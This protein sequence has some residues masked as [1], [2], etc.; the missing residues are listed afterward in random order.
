[1]AY[2]AP[3]IGYP[4]GSDTVIPLFELSGELMVAYGR[5]IKDFSVNKYSRVTSVKSTVGTYLQFNPLD[6][7]RMT[8]LPASPHWAPGT[9]RPT[10]GYETLG[11]SAQPFRTSREAWAVTLDKRSV[12]V[13]NF[14]VMKSHTAALGQR[15]MTFRAYQTCAA[16]TNTNNF[17][18]THVSTATLLN[19]AGF[20]Q[21]GT[22]SDPRWM[23]TLNAAAR[24]IQQD[25]FSAVRYGHL[26]VLMNHN[27]ALRLAATRELREYLMQQS[28]SPKLIH[29]TDPELAGMYGLPK[30]YYNYTIVVEDAFYNPQNR[31]NSAEGGVTV[32][33]DNTAVMF[34]ADGDLEVPEGAT[35]F[36]TCHMFAYEELTLETKDDPWNRMVEMGAVMDFQIQIVAPVTG[37]IIQNLFY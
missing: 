37:F 32:M 17:P 13:A 27:T 35:S 8:A 5:N 14:P 2:V 6:I 29:M 23:N 36:S 24:I 21:S 25:T 15:A 34:L 11:F 20:V 12:D 1:M 22:T 4:G 16:M 33:P 31:G 7:V 18:A 28:G 26:S 3:T 9:P 19:G 10:G 30:T